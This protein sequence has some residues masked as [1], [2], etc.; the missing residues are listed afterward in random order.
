MS[1]PTLRAFLFDDLPPI[2]ETTGQRL[3]GV[4]A[5]GEVSPAVGPDDACAKCGAVAWVCLRV[6]TNAAQVYVALDAA[7]REAFARDGRIVFAMDELATILQG[8][9]EPF[10]AHQALTAAVAARGAG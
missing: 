1:T 3:A 4:C 6:D 2:L 7:R 5:C 10:A 9:T 8:V